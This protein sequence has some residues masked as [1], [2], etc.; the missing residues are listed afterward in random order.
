[1]YGF[2]FCF[3][4]LFIP[5]LI[6]P[7]PL[8]TIQERIG[9]LLLA[10]GLLALIP[11]ISFQYHY[12]AAIMPL[13]YLRFLQSIHRLGNWRPNAKPWGLALAV[14][15]IALIPVQFSR[16]LWKLFTDGEYAAPMA[17][18]Y[19]DTV[20]ELEALPGRQLVLVRYAPNHDV[21]QEWVFNRADIDKARV[22]WAREMN[23]AE[24]AALVR[25]FH[26]RRVWLLEPDH[27]PP[28]LTPYGVTMAQSAQGLPAEAGK[29]E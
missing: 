3:Y 23:P 18:P 17:Q 27:L 26:D 15:L 10:G 5:T 6:W 12:A 28:R 9:V 20:R 13:F 2:F 29:A 19:H 14:L 25:Y 21:Y 1:M 24:D 4:P 8:Q 11:V 16:D 7:Y 22:V